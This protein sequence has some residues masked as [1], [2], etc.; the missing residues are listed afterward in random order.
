M[1]PLDKQISTLRIASERNQQQ[2]SSVNP[3]EEQ[4]K[5]KNDTR[6]EKQ[7]E[8]YEKVEYKIQAILRLEQFVNESGDLEYDEFKELL[9]QLMLDIR[10]TFNQSVVD[11][12]TRYTQIQNELHSIVDREDNIKSALANEEDQGQ[13]KNEGLTNELNELS[14]RFSELSQENDE[15]EMNDD[16]VFLAKMDLFYYSVLNKKNDVLTFKDERPG[17]ILSVIGINVMD[18]RGS[19][20]IQFSGLS[21]NIILSSNDYDRYFGR[22]SNGKHFVGTVFN[23]IR[24]REDREVTIKHE[25]RHNITES[26]V[27]NV[28]Y[29]DN[30]IGKLMQDVEAMDDAY[31]HEALRKFQSTIILQKIETYYKKNYAEIVADLD[32]LVEGK[33][34]T[35]LMNYRQTRD[36]LLNFV[37][38]LD[39][40]YEGRY[41]E[42]GDA[43]KQRINILEDKFLEY[44]FELAN[45]FYFADKINKQE[46]AKALVV[47][48]EGNTRKIKRHLEFYRPEYDY[49]SFALLNVFMGKLDY[50]EQLERK[51][52]SKEYALRSMFGVKQ[53]TTAVQHKFGVKITDL[54]SLKK[55]AEAV[56]V[57]VNDKLLTN[58]EME[59]LE[60]KL[61]EIDEDLT[62]FR[63]LDFSKFGISVYM[64][65][66][67]ILE[68]IQALLKPGKYFLD[69]RNALFAGCF[70]YCVEQGNFSLL[71]AEIDKV[72]D[73]FN[74]DLMLR[75]VVDDMEMDI[76]EYID[77]GYID[78][79]NKLQNTPLK[80][81]LKQI[82]AE[83]DEV[84]DMLQVQQEKWEDIFSNNNILGDKN[85][86]KRN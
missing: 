50:L 81:F 62:F 18:L 13:S 43:V 40:K 77:R 55:I 64:Q 4:N 35:F 53:S 12:Y 60:I 70:N 17:E 57:S 21:V 68:H 82:G 58:E 84:R 26:F 66:V 27:A 45:V 79:N 3:R 72:K 52:S 33:M 41:K 25:N 78:H 37:E 56:Q 34:S 47:L 48:F 44:F 86:N 46:E 20:E 54:N 69:F 11:E 38:Y 51:M 61:D 6:I 76:D 29:I 36:S 14:Q 2:S 24:D 16:V 63:R 85:N 30:L 10:S 7:K 31:G 19:F 32:R 67:E 28:V 75:C 8:L 74:R 42:L 5:Q 71:L 9:E 65:A 1:T 49:E 22:I 23:V 73:F 80:E 39:E 59:L 83:E 15:L